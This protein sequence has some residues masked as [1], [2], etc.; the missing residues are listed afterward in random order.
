MS[1]TLFGKHGR[2]AQRCMGQEDMQGLSRKKGCSGSV[3]LSITDFYR[4]SKQH[5]LRPR[6]SFLV[7]GSWSAYIGTK[8]YLY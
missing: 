1:H 8:Y 3:R 7:S 4:S 5:S 2:T 6:K